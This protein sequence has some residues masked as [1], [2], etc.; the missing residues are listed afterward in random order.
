MRQIELTQDQQQIFTQALNARLA[1]VWTTMPGIVQS[2]DPVKQTA[3]VKPAI[4]AV[5]FDQDGN[6]TPVELPLLVDCPVI[7]PSGGGFTLTFPVALG[8]ECVIFFGARCIDAWWQSGG[9][10]NQAAMRMHDLSDGFVLVGVSSVP[11]VIANISTTATQLRSADGQTYVEV[12]PSEIKVVAQTVN[13]QATNATVTASNSATIDAP[14]VD[15]NA[16]SA[17]NITTPTATINGSATITGNV[18]IDG[19]LTI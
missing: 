7:F 10:Q 8:N 11:N 9:V 17:A 5:Q 13:V 2:F 3:E 14:T 1:S 19:T 12:G 16:S 15:V 6:S 18:V 4:R